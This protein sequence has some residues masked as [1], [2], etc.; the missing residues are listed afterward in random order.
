MTKD[1]KKFFKILLVTL[2]FANFFYFPFAH[3]NVGLRTEGDYVPGEVLVKYKKSK[4]NLETLIGRNRALASADKKSL[5]VEEHFQKENISLLKIEDNKTVEDA[6]AE[7][8][9]DPDV[10]YV[11][12]NYTRNISTISSN[13]TDKALL[14]GLDNTG[15][16]INGDWG[17]IT[18]TADADID[19]PEAWAVN[20]GTN[21]DVIVAVIDIGVSYTHPDLSANM[22]DGTNCVSNT[23]APLGGC[24]HGYDYASNDV[25]PL[26]S[27]N[28]NYHGT[29]V[30]GIIAAEKNNNT[31]I[32]GI[33]PHAKIMALRFALTVSSE[34][35]AIDF[36]IQN[37]AKVIN[38][39]FGGAGFSQAEYDAINRFKDAGGLFVAAAGN[40]GTSNDSAHFYPSDYDLPN[41]I[42]VAATDQND[43]ITSFSN[44]G[45]TSVDVGA[46]GENILSTITQNTYAYLSGTSMAT[47]YTAGLAALIWGYQNDL[48]Y[49]DVKNIILNDGDVNTD[50]TGVT[51]SGKRI[52]AQKSLFGADIF[53][54]ESIHDAATEGTDP[55]DYT[56]GSRATLQT[57]IDSATTIIS[58]SGSTESDIASAVSTLDAAVTTFLAGLVPADFTALDSEI[59]TAQALHDGATESTTPGDFIVG[60]KV[61]L[62]S[63]IDTASAIPGT[64]S[65]TV[66]NS[67]LTVL[68]SAVDTFNSSIVPLSDLSLLT[69]TIAD[70]QTLH[71]GA[72]E[73]VLVGQ[74]ATG[75]KDT[76]Q[77]AIDT[78]SSVTDALPQ[79][80]VDSALSDLNAAIL[81]FQNDRV[82]ADITASAGTGG[83][84]SPTGTVTVTYGN[85]QTFTITALNGFS[86][87]KI[88]VDGSPAGTDQIYDFNDV[89]LDHTISVTFRRNSSGGGGGGGGGGI[90][91][92][93]DVTVPIITPLA[94]LLPAVAPSDCLSGYLF[95]PST[96]MPCGATSSGDLPRF[97][98][99][100]TAQLPYVFTRTL[101]VGMSGNDVFLIQK[102]LNSNGYVI[103]SSGLGSKGSETPY[104]GMK[105]LLAVKNFQKAKGLVPDG[106]I[107]KMTIGKMI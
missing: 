36:A 25:T 97:L 45:A 71:D 63:A 75:S 35:K 82:S 106:I 1:I 91:P 13:D 12:P 50:L 84:I 14:W 72:V 68:A 80:T 85:D 79:E 33:A 77:S 48:S 89:I 38:A 20:E 19:A 47:P 59:A 2:I 41:I 66:V 43:A 53:R 26:P 30:A 103:A 11:E 22:W 92:P 46:P 101:K 31:G 86:I 56:V 107:G 78:A 105:T 21:A 44:F 5:S 83:S 23:G 65:Q 15:Q 3:A 60:S 94:P 64:A 8:T 51:V 32:I 34:V 6:I 39:S 67:A 104:F 17:D 81:I 102:Y 9:A 24:N 100:Q 90:I 87:D 61:I 58:N 70:A 16:E 7:F 52:N 74:F 55:G 49:T 69:S 37:G 73:G 4:I 54:A 10:Q 99:N 76:L 57:V 95:S 88:L 40:D 96:G 98:T 28:S 27:S 42:S 62:Q 18:G 29:H 93:E